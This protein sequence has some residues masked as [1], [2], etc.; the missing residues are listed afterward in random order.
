MPDVL[1][2]RQNEN[3]YGK[4]GTKVADAVGIRVTAEKKYQEFLPKAMEILQAADV[5]VTSVDLDGV[6]FDQY[7]KDGSEPVINA[8][9]LQTIPLHMKRIN[10]VL[11]PAGKKGY[12]WIN[13]NREFPVVAQIM[14]QFDPENTQGHVA[15]VLEGG[16]VLGYQVSKDLVMNNQDAVLDES[17]GEVKF[18]DCGV[19]KIMHQD[20]KGNIFLSESLLEAPHLRDIRLG[21]KKLTVA[22]A[23][24]ALFTA[25]ESRLNEFGEKA[26]M[27]EGRQ[28]MVTV[29][30]VD[31][32][33][34]VTEPGQDISAIKKWHV[35]DGSPIIAIVR[36]VLQLEDAPLDDLPFELIYYPFD[37]G[38]DVQFKGLNKTFGQKALVARMKSLGVI[39]PDERV[40][41][42]HDGDSGS[43]GIEFVDEELKTTCVVLSV[44]NA[45]KGLID[46][47]SLLAT[48]PHRKGVRQGLYVLGSLAK[49]L[50]L[51]N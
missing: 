40:A 20:G 51:T 19:A 43:D 3:V 37:G 41:I 10:K 49:A 36:E 12:I 31:P 32:A 2:P 13:T 29:R 25:F 48:Y 21:Q 38:F 16:H 6:I 14:E 34:V 4:V 27:P 46:K 35:P 9:E 39:K 8:P 47:S 33:Q 44:A 22:E 18:A 11:S 30:G 28:G 23:R 1:L 7:N 5:I 24:E 50:R 17:K 42:L 26:W 45:D 15:A